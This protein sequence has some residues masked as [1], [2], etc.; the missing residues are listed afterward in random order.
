MEAR[1]AGIRHESGLVEPPDVTTHGAG[2]DGLG[3]LQATRGQYGV[4]A[5]L[6]ISLNASTLAGATMNEKLAIK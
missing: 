1:S 5:A 3:P 4:V 6:A 2:D